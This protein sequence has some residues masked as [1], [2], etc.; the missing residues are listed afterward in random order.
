MVNILPTLFFWLCLAQYQ[1]D[2]CVFKAKIRHQPAECVM[3][4]S[5]IAEL[6]DCEELSSFFPCTDTE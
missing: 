1:Y 3:T 5:L 2:G 6:T 4:V